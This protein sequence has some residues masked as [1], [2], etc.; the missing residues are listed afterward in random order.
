MTEKKTAA[1]RKRKKAAAFYK[2]VCKRCKHESDK[3]YP[4]ADVKRNL[5]GK[6]PFSCESCGAKSGY[7]WQP[8]SE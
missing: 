3:Q 2:P 7:T 8:V 4:L 1:P 5:E 6:N